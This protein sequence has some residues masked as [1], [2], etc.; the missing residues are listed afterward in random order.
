MTVLLD[1]NVLIARVDP[2]HEHHSLAR[3][4]LAALDPAAAIATCPLT[5]NGFLRIYGHPAY[6][7][8][9]GSPESAAPVLRA[10]RSLPQHVFLPDDLSV[11]DPAR[12]HSLAGVGSQQLTDLYLLALA[13]KHSALFATFDRKIDPIRVAGGPEALRIIR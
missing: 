9:P 12:I 7:G 11:A 3:G 2:A 6:P 8:G 1:I 5:E 10:I 4:W 13:A